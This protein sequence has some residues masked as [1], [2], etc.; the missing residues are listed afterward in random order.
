MDKI[1]RNWKHLIIISLDIENYEIE[2]FALVIFKIRESG[3]W[4]LLRMKY[5]LY[6]NYTSLGYNITKRI[7][8]VAQTN[9]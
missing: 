5:P 2:M 6:V 8:Y 3:V 7:C 1:Y 4:S 9:N